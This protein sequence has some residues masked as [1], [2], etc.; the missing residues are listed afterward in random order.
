MP[1]IYGTGQDTRSPA[2]VQTNQHAVVVSGSSRA[3]RAGRD[4][5]F[6]VTFAQQQFRKAWCQLLAQGG[7]PLILAVNAPVEVRRPDPT[8]SRVS[9]VTAFKYACRN[10]ETGHMASDR[11][12]ALIVLLILLP[13]ASKSSEALPYMVAYLCDPMPITEA[14]IDRCVTVNPVLPASYG[15]LRSDWHLRNDAP[16]AEL[17]KRCDAYLTRHSSADQAQFKKSVHELNA[18][19]TSAKI[20]QI[21]ANPEICHSLLRKIAAGQADLQNFVDSQL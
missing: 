19:A 16:G 15:T 14:A 7:F 12:S 5:R 2:Y 8:R 18:K 4:R 1:V 3:R 17:K 10:K 9:P 20:A 21:D 6:T 13:T 11:R